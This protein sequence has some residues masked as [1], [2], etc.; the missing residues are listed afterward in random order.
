LLADSSVEY[1]HARSVTRGCYLFRI[2]RGPAV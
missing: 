2:E 1:V